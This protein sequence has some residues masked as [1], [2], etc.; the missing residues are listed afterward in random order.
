[1]R[2]TLNSKNNLDRS[3]FLFLFFPFCFVYFRLEIIFNFLPLR[4]VL[5]PFGLPT[6][7][8]HHQIGTYRFARLLESMKRFRGL[9]RL[10]LGD[11][12]YKCSTS[13]GVL[14]AL[15]FQGQHHS[16]LMSLYCSRRLAKQKFQIDQQKQRFFANLKFSLRVRFPLKPI[17]AYGSAAVAPSRFRG[18]PAA[19]IRNSKEAWGSQFRCILTPEAFT[20]QR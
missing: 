5:S 2:F 11:M 12:S 14:A 20:S 19:P 16:S 18:N 10:D 7:S 6:K 8:Y 15:A 1:M 3:E 4:Y 17:I 13:T 9:N